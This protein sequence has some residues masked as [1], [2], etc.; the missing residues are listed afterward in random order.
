[1]GVCSSF[2]LV[3]RFIFNIFFS[4]IRTTYCTEYLLYI[5]TFNY[6][7]L[8]TIPCYKSVFLYLYI[9]RFPFGDKS[10]I[11]IWELYVQPTDSQGRSVLNDKLTMFNQTLNI[12]T[13]KQWLY[14]NPRTSESNRL[15]MYVVDTY[16]NWLYIYS[17]YSYYI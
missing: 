14:K 12:L 4:F 5:K 16:Y 7:L 13:W 11:K 3:I 15:Y 9:R 2:I 8:Y 6:I 10:F 17:L 1:M